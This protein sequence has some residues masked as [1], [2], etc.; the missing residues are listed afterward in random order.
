M[1]PPAFPDDILQPFIPMPLELVAPDNINKD[2]PTPD[3]KTEATPSP[4]PPKKTKKL[5]SSK[6]G[7]EKVPELASELD[8]ESDLEATP[9][10]LPAKKE[11]QPV[12]Q[13]RGRPR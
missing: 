6:K 7:K 13:K 9:S 2:E 11:K 1:N 12:H 5:S 4:L 8:D 3:S 10:P